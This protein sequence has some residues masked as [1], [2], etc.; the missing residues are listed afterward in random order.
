MRRIVFHLM[1]SLDGY[2]E[3]PDGD[4]SWHRVDDE[5]HTFFNEQLDRVSAFLE[6]RVSY[7]LMEAYWPTADQDPDAPPPMAQFAGI[8]RDTPKIVYSRTLDEVGPNATLVRDVVPAEVQA[9]QELPGGELVLGGPDLAAAFRR[10]DLNDEYRFF[11]NPVLVGGGRQVFDP[12]QA[13]SDLRLVG[14]RTFSNGVVM[15]RHERVR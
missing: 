2:F 15:L 11:V 13:P 5:L 3:G 4:L 1:V 8:W 14:T 9:L 10:H 7:Q 6:G 12:G